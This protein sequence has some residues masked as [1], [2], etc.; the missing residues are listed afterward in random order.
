METE[1]E[2]AVEFCV[3]AEAR[4]RNTFLPTMVV[5]EGVRGVLPSLRL[6]RDRCGVPPASSRVQNALN[7]LEIAVALMKE[8]LDEEVGTAVH[9]EG[10]A[11]AQP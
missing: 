8:R 5:L 6:L 7:Q 4:Q 2:K 11:D 9:A 3:A 1:L 10:T